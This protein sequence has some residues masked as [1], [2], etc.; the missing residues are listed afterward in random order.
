MQCMEAHTVKGCQMVGQ[1]KA[2]QA[3]SYNARQGHKLQPKVTFPM[4]VTRRK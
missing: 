2:R 4:R 1:H 3:W